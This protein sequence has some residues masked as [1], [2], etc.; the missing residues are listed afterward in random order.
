MLL[1]PV[2]DSGQIWAE[3]VGDDIVGVAD[4]E[5]A[6]PDPWVSGDVLEHLGVVVG[7]E[8]NLRGWCVVGGEPADE[9]GQPGERAPLEL[10]VLVE[11]VVRFPGFVGDDE[12]VVLVLE[13]VV[14]HMKLATSSS[15]IR[16]QAWKQWRSWPADS[17]VK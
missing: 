9:V 4:E 6:V 7:S 16:R 5:R 3:V 14:E 11:E 8:R 13:D 10:G 17:L 1:G 2:P 12:V 15:S